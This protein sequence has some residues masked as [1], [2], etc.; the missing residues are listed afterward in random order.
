M[1]TTSWFR[2]YH[3][4][5]FMTQTLPCLQPHGLDFIMSTTAWLRL[6]YA[7]LMVHIL[8]HVYNIMAQHHVYNLMAQTLSCLKL[9]WLSLQPHG[10]QSTS[11]WFTE[12]TTSWLTV[13]ILMAQ[14]TTS[15]LTVY[16]LMARSLQPHGSQ[17]LQSHGSQSIRILAIYLSTCPLDTLF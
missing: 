7:Y 17:S 4:Y 12:S 9:H 15:W 16:N 11:S 10:S 6:Y 13:Y 8:D 5:N 1:S 3:V 2:V 14:S